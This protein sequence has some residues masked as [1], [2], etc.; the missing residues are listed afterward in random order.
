MPGLCREC[1][2]PPRY[3]SF[4]TRCA[5]LFSRPAKHRERA[6]ADIGGGDERKAR[7][8][9]KMAAM[10]AVLRQRLI[11]KITDAWHTG[12]SEDDAAR[13]LKMARS[14]LRFYCTR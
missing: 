10:R 13:M 8:Q 14:R 5:K 1:G 3:H 12:A 11:T 2:N 4:C 9:E 6:C 7:C